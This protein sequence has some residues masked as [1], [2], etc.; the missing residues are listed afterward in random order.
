M[1]PDGHIAVIISHTG[2]NERLAEIVKMLRR[3]GT[4]VIVIS[5]VREGIVS[6][7]ADEFCVILTDKPEK[8][9]GFSVCFPIL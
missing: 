5:S 8:A 9:G 7:Q 3:S 6:R 2:E 1:P 4:K